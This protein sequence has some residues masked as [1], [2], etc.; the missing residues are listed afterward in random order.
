MRS[1]SDLLAKGDPRSGQYHDGG[2]ITKR[3]QNPILVRP[4]DHCD[5]AAETFRLLSAENDGM[6][7]NSDARWFVL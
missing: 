7:E 1:F 6:L 2:H 3:A 5:G 4:K